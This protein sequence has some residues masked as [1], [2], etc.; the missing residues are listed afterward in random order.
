MNLV[1]VLS[2]ASFYSQRAPRTLEKYEMILRRMARVGIESQDDATPENLARFVN[3]R[4]AV[5]GAGTAA[6]HCWALIAVLG[7]L[8]DTGRLDGSCVER[9]RRVCPATRKP[10]ALSAQFFSHEDFED[11]R[12]AARWTDRSPL[13]DWTLC[14]A[15]HTGLR[16]GELGRLQWQDVDVRRRVINV[17]STPGAPTKTRRSRMVPITRELLAMLTVMEHPGAQL[18]RSEGRGSVL[19]LGRHVSTRTLSKRLE[20][21]A[22]RTRLEATLTVCRHTRASWWLLRGVAPARVALWMGHSVQTLL[23][24]YAGVARGFDPE[25]DRECA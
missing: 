4:L 7:H 15:V 3:E 20:V 13:T 6:S 1:D 17:L 19:S 11:L 9:L 14:L 25:A 16:A 8:A 24:H 5:V 21:V 22:E 10:E 2:E 18:T 12:E 23:A